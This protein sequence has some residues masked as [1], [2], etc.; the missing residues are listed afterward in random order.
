LALLPD[1][2]KEGNEASQTGFGKPEKIYI[3]DR[4]KEASGDGGD[5]T[6]LGHDGGEIVE[7]NT[8]DRVGDKH[9]EADLDKLEAAG[10]TSWVGGS[11]ADK[12][13]G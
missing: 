4:L 1:D 12:T 3:V 13:Q 9:V 8:E 7:T 5:F 11:S 2:S 6:K 10:D